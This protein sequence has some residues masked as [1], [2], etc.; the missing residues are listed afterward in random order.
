MSA[1]NAGMS[2][3]LK[4]AIIGV[5]ALTGAT[6]FADRFNHYKVGQLKGFTVLSAGG[7]ALL[8]SKIPGNVKRSFSATFAN[9]SQEEVAEIDLHLHISSFATGKTTYDGPS[10]T[11]KEFSINLFAHRGSLL[12]ACKG[13]LSTPVVQDYP[14]R[15]WTTDTVDT[16]TITEI[17]TYKGTQDY[18]DL[19]HLFT[20]FNFIKEPE[21]LAILKKDPSIC[22]SQESSGLTAGHMMIVTQHPAAIE[23]VLKNGGSIVKPTKDGTTMM[24]FAAMSDFPDTIDYIV[25]KGGN[26]NQQDKNST[27][28]I[29]AASIGNLAGVKWMLAHGAKADLE[30]TNGNNPAH[31]AIGGGYPEILKALVQAGASPKGLTKLGFSWMHAATANAN[32]L[33]YVAKYGIPIDIVNPQSG[34]TPLFYSVALGRKWATRWLLQHGANPDIVDKRGKTMYDYAKRLNTLNTDRFVREE[35][36]KYST[37]KKK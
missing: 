33:P 13:S 37:Y 14:G 18:H 30:V 26:I 31:A 27:P 19:G 7:H 25:K 11:V 4:S 22:R 8:E 20:K 9:F 32:M 34:M 5:A 15:F 24:D 6:S 3:V 2:A 36:K 21:A 35:V 23:F 28:L 17:R 16:L 12:P 10:I 1:Y 29:R